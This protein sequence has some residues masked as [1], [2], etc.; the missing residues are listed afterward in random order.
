[1]GELSHVGGGEFRKIN[2]L[3]E[4]RDGSPLSVFNNLRWKPK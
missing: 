2:F 3:K 1:M 4:E